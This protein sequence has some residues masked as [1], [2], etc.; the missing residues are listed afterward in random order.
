MQRRTLEHFCGCL[1]GGAIGDAL[2][3][4]VEFEKRGAIHAR[5]GPEGIREPDCQGRA[6]A[7]IT[8]DTQ[9][10]LFTA[11]GLLRAGVR[12]R[13]HGL[14]HA[15]SVIHHA[16][17]RWLKTQGV[18]P[19]FDIG[20]DGWLYG[21]KALHV[22]RAPGNACISALRRSRSFGDMARNDSKGCGGVMRMAPVGLFLEDADSVFDVAS[23]AA[24]LTHGHP[25]GRLAAAAFAVIIYRLVAGD[26]LDAAVGAALNALADRPGNGE[27]AAALERAARLAREGAPSE[28]KVES[29]GEGWVAEEALAIAV[30]AAL[31]HPADYA[32]AVTLAVNHSGD[33]DSTGAICGNIVGLLLGEKGIP[34]DWIR[35]VELENV[36]RTVAADLL[37]GYRRDAEWWEKYPGW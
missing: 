36:I 12:N 10:T 31:S 25:T 4:P 11:E 15:P 9:M 30:Y 28:E 26:G 21:V 7:G 33:S 32:A 29:L 3:W 24:G 6:F 18:E 23:E 17:L 35:R 5:Y 14:C 19:A 1:L 27:T 8:D 16:Y 13:E 34:A 2:G 37:T 20:T 22:Q